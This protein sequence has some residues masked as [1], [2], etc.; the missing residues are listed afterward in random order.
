MLAGARKVVATDINPMAVKNARFNAEQ[1]GLA[2]RFEVRLVP[3]DDAGAYSVIQASERFDLVIYKRPVFRL[4]R[5]GVFVFLFLVAGG[6]GRNLRLD[7]WRRRV[8]EG[9]PAATV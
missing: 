8:G 6:F 3:P 2:E 9:R 7:G 4:E 1:L 5:D